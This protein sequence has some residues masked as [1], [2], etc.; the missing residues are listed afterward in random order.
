MAA[1]IASIESGILDGQ[2]KYLRWKEKHLREFYAPEIEAMAGKL[3]SSLPPE[4]V[5]EL[6]KRNPRSFADVVTRIAQA[7][8]E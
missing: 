6:A 8:G 2:T 3:L 7:K 5:N 1:T 4:V